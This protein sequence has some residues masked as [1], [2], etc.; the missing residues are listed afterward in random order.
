MPL[1]SAASPW[2]GSR[3][4]SGSQPG[5]HSQCN[6]AGPDTQQQQHAA[7][8]AARAPHTAC[9]CSR[10][11]DCCCSCKQPCPGAAA[12]GPLCSPTTAASYCSSSDSSAAVLAGGMRASA[13]DTDWTAAT[14]QQEAT[15]GGR[16][17][18]EAAARFAAST[19]SFAATLHVCTWMSF[20][21]W[22]AL[23]VRSAS[24]ELLD[25]P[26]KIHTATAVVSWSCCWA[27]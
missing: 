11:P 13:L 19:V 12:P 10:L 26:S 18:P 8:A 22:I 16:L 27:A 15:H 17:L 23:H 14:Q 2:Q 20:A 4:Y 1:I 5:R 9:V 25:A 24:G 3:Q 7:A 21:E 6:M